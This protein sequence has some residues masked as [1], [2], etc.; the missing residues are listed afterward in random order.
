[1][2]LP[3]QKVHILL[4][5]GHYDILY[6]NGEEDPKPGAGLAP[7]ASPLPVASG[8]GA[9]TGAGTSAVTI[10]IAGAGAGADAG[11]GARGYSDD[12]AWVIKTDAYGDRLAFDFCLS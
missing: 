12:T 9:D 11:A 4:K 10:A 2:C 7:T 1:M 3:S 6:H 5:P 8:A